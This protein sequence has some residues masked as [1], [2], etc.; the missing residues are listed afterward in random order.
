MPGMCARQGGRDSMSY[1]YRF[2][3]RAPYV[4][5]ATSVACDDDGWR[6][7]RPHP[8][9]LSSFEPES[10]VDGGSGFWRVSESGKPP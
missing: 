2:A 9:R 3:H 6:E 1:V 7:V 4:A 8:T 10:G 5:D